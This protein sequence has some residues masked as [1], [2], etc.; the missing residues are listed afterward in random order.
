[1][2]PYIG[3]IAQPSVTFNSTATTQVLTGL[4]PGANYHFKIAARNAIG[5]GPMSL[6]AGVPEPPTILRNALPGNGQ[7][8]VSWTAPTSDGGPPI[9]GYAVTPY[10]GYF[11]LPPITFNS[12]STTQTVTRLTN[13]TTYRFKVAAI[14]RAGTGR[15]SKVTNP[16]TPMP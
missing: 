4:Q 7:A 15:T 2:T 10:I 14:N 1:V 9:T 13:G 5:N 8:T 16:V 3:Y 6:T 11:P 12:T